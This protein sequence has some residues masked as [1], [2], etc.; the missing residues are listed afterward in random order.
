MVRRRCKRLCPELST[1]RFKKF[2]YKLAAVIREQLG[3]YA[4]WDDP[5]NGEDLRH[6]VRGY[7]RC[8]NGS[9]EF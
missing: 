2:V 9:R 8:Q 1:Q 4:V 7:P 3:W 5:S 6:S